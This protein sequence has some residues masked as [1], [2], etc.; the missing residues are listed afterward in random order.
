MHIPKPL[1][2][3]LSILDKYGAV[4]VSLH[5]FLDPLV[6]MEIIYKRFPA[7]FEHMFRETVPFYFL[8]ANPR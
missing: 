6:I 4:D 7:K 2:V 3:P 5:S 1:G 8:V